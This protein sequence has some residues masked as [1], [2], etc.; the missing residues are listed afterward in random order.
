VKKP[1]P[2]TGFRLAAG[3]KKAGLIKKETIWARFRNGPL[4][5]FAIRNN[6]GKMQVGL[7]ATKPNK[8]WCRLNPTYKLQSGP[9]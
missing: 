9:G 6:T 4:L 3:K 5:G 8:A 2:H 7:S 1:S